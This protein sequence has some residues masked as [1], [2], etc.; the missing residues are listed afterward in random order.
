MRMRSVLN[1]L[2]LLAM[3]IV[4]V[5]CGS[6]EEARFDTLSVT[7]E[8]DLDWA[9]RGETVTVKIF[10]DNSRGAAVTVGGVP[11]EVTILNGN[12]FSFVVPQGAPTG[13]QGVVMELPSRTLT[14]SLHVLGEDVARREFM[15]VLEPGTTAQDV[16]EVLDSID[17]EMLDG[18]YSLGAESGPCSGE[19]FKI[20]ISG[21]GTGQAL[22]ELNRR[23]D[24]IR[25]W[26]SDPLSGYSS[27]TIDHLGAIGAGPQLLRSQTGAGTT[28]AVIDTGVSS[29]KEL[30]SRLLLGD[31]YDFVD[32]GT[33]PQDG[34]PGG[35]GTAV[36]V[37][38]AG[39]SSGV[40]QQAWVLPVRVCDDGGTCYTD[41]VLAG[42]CHSLATAGRR[43]GGIDKLVLNLSLGGETPVP[44]IREALEFAVQ[45]GAVVVASG[46]NDGERGS[47]PHYPAAFRLGGIVAVAALD[48]SI[49]EEVTGDWKPASF[50]TRG[51]YIDV[52]APGTDLTSG[53]PSGGYASSYTGTS[54]AA[55]LVSG[56]VALWREAYPE[57]SAAEVEGRLKSAARPLEYPAEAVGAGMLDLSSE[58][59]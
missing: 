50:S 3:G 43:L 29:H 10:G 36:A 51:D 47:P 11:A 49:T 14:D 22:T 1:A 19:R 31:G 33:T 16:A 59:R 55:A 24:G 28:I 6:S 45:K 8:M 39:S 44:A 32:D 52:S 21:M 58:P 17:Y 34:Y 20:R 27:G 41:D 38:A 46:G 2:T 12:V 5:A 37:L 30:G 13:R 56:G 57:L 35:H 18:P 25:L 15:L 48:A 40:A 7:A 42:I 9:L 4:L 54:Y 26:H 53:T 23:T